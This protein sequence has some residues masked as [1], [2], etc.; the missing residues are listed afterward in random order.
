MTCVFGTMGIALDLLKLRY[1]IVLIAFGSFLTTASAAYHHHGDY[2]STSRMAQ[3]TGVRT[4]WHDLLGQHC[5][6]FGEERTVRYY[7]RCHSPRCLLTQ[8]EIMFQVALPI[9]KPSGFQTTDD[10]KIRLSFEGERHLTPWLKVLGGKMD[11]RVP[12]VRVELVRSE[13]IKIVLQAQNKYTSIIEHFLNRGRR[14]TA[15]AI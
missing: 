11:H 5:P 9:P 8:K 10:Y 7:D 12:Y 3:F 4:H 14:S 13:L 6:R 2:V 15:G 1:A